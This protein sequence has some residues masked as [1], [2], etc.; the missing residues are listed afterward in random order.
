VPGDNEVFARAMDAAGNVAQTPAVRVTH[1]R[2]AAWAAI[3]PEGGRIE[4]A[5]GAMAGAALVVPADASSPVRTW[6]L[7]LASEAPPLPAGW[8]GLGVPIAFEHS[9]PPFTVPVTIELPYDASLV[10]VVRG[11]IDE[12]RLLQVESAGGRGRPS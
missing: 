11:H 8:V 5:E 9:G 7:R 3:G 12:A 2:P 1:E 10:P 4:V 6:W